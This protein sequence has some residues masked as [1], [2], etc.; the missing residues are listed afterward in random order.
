[1]ISIIKNFISE[2]KL[3]LALGLIVILIGMTV[4]TQKILDITEN[5]AFC[6]KNCHIMRPYYDSWRT[7]NHN[8]TRC[9]ECH[10]EPG[11]VGHIKGKINGL[12]QFYSYETTTNEMTEMLFAKVS[13]DNCLVCHQKQIFSSNVSFNGI[14]FNHSGHLLQPK[15]GI[16]LACTSCHSMIVIGMKEHESVTDPSCGQCHPNIKQNDI[17]HIIVTD[18]TCFT[19]HFRDVPGNTSIS[20]CPSCHGPPKQLYKN[21]TA[22]N[23]TNH[24]KRGFECTTCHTNISTGANNIIPT[25]KC[26]TCHIE[27][28]RANKY[29]D[30]GLVHKVHVTDNKIACYN[31][32][33]TV[34]HSPTIKDNL[35]SGCHSNQH[36]TNWLNIHSTHVP[37]EQ[38]CSDCHE[39]KFCEDCHAKVVTGRNITK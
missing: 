24:L 13:D 14:N 18:S 28:D 9:V 36:P 12:L 27:Q 15:R 3:P 16:K 10:Y 21:Y 8:K 29:N 38:I 23:H 7:S 26:I 39:P 1:M 30:F 32:H 2:H 25:G 17:G 34:T 5:P 4:I 19:C 33:S 20:G 31:C 37:G 22:F 11:L 35:C 6:G